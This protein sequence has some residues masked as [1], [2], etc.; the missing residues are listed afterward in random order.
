VNSSQACQLRLLGTPSVAAFDG[1]PIGRRVVQRHRIALLALLSLS[2]GH[3]LSRER[4]LGYL[5]PE[6]DPERARQLLNQAVYQLRKG[7][8]E[9]A[10]ESSGDEL[11]LNVERVR[12]DVVEFEAAV[13]SRRHSQAVA[14]YRGP[15]LDGFY[16][17]EAV[18]F[19]RW[20]EGERA[21]LA[22]EFAKEL[23][24]LAEAAEENRDFP[25]SAEWWTKRAAHD[26]FDSR[27]ALLVMQALEKAGNR[28]AA[29]Q[30]GATHARL[31]H[32][33]FGI[34]PPP[35]VIAF[36]E[37]LR[38]EA[39]QAPAHV[40]PVRANAKPLAR[41]LAISSA[42]TPRP[43]ADP[44]VEHVEAPSDLPPIVKTSRLW[45]VLGV[46]AAAGAGALLFWFAKRTNERA[47]L[48]D[49]AIPRIEHYLDVADWEHAYRLARE[50]DGRVQGSREIAELWPRLTWL[51]TITSKPA[52]ATVFR[53]SYTAD[54]SAWEVLGRTPLEQIRVPYGLSRIRLELA[55]YRPVMRALGGA[56]INWRELR[57]G[58]PDHLLV[59][60]EIY[61]LDKPRDLPADMVRV[62]GG[63]LMSGRDTVRFSDFLMG[64]FEVTNAEFKR[65][66]DAGGYRRRELWPPIV[67]GSDT[68]A[69]PEAMMR[70]IDRTGRPGPSTWEAGDYP[71]GEGEFPVSGVSWYEATAYARFTGRELPTANH[72]QHALANSLFPWLLPASNFGGSGSR[73][74]TPS[75]AMS[76][77]EVFD[78]TG[79]V[80]EW[81]ATAVGSE[82]IILGGS[83]SDPY[84]I[85]G[86]PDVSAR[87]EDRS[88]GNG[89]RLVM[90]SDDV[91]TAARMRARVPT[92]TT[93]A[94]VVS[95]PPLRDEVYEAYSRVFDYD[96]S[97]LEPVVE[98]VDTTRL[99][100]RE[101]IT[102]DAGYAGG[103]L[104]IHLYRPTGLK[105]PYQTVVY[106]PGWD[107]FWLAD[108]DE[109][110][111]KQMD[112]I[113][114]SGR[115]VAF[116][117]FSGT[118]ERRVSSKVR[119]P[120]FGT[121]EYRDNTI[122]TI[123]ELRRTVDYI[124]TRSDLDTA[125]IAF[126]GYSWGGVNGP[127]ALA[128]EPRFRTA[129]IHIGLLPP[130]AT[131]PEVDPLNSLARV[132]VPTLMLSGEFDPMVPRE[133]ATR[134]FALIGTP[135]ARKRQVWAIGGH[136]VP[137]ALVIRET[138]DWL[139]RYLG[140][141]SR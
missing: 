95:R 32:D 28:A 139:D 86:T 53:Q 116:P 100:I 29:L 56:H 10:I 76:H 68:L 98:R 47:W 77:V 5:W 35:D 51:V 58:N 136:F 132:R 80:R 89:I 27:V 125:A 54:T 78:L 46:L 119:T 64:R 18:E 70:F 12:S 67:V 124:G 133:N 135:D 73:A 105:A 106:W 14:F 39:A 31:L 50:A 45:R 138:L 19:E 72:W 44:A 22:G 79:N 114:K 15:F 25:A 2:P 96:N 90:T 17:S 24:S 43:L 110:F 23:E 97:E 30:H 8:G 63:K 87:P 38:H 9:D 134:Y 11:R 117:I 49:E 62:P 123:K 131:T 48:L 107:T 61:R 74:V 42:S 69:W 37:R 59:G 91:L 102:I 4:V 65:F 122:H 109:Y 75:R 33:E 84:Y 55:G 34:A 129:I 7:L 71:A 112:F 88:A 1:S 3:G 126:Y 66:V 81:T 20:L 113:I 94:T 108:A 99:W 130:M 57:P 36:A 120:A 52:G 118:F 60:P 26:P 121:A 127:L 41:A 92:R 103:R 16:L 85:A 111:A 137:R 104:P 140:P 13:A 83:W 141:T 21:R 128:Q 6:S 115:A 40:L 101:R 82:V 93:A